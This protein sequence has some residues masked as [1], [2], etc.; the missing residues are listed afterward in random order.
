MRTT[1]LTAGTS[2]YLQNAQRYFTCGPIVKRWWYDTRSDRRYA[3]SGATMFLQVC[4]ANLGSTDTVKSVTA[5]ISRLDTMV[6]MGTAASLTF[7]N[8]P[9]GREVISEASQGM[10]VMYAPKDTA[11]R[12][13][14]TISSE[15]YPL[16]TDTLRISTGVFTD[17]KTL[18]T[19]FSL[20]QNY[21]NPF[22]PSTAIRYQLAAVS[23]VTL[24]V[25]DLLGREV[26]TL[27]NQR[28]NPGSHTVMF[29]A[30]KLPSGVYFYT[31]NAGVFRETKRMMLMK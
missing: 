7:G 10:K 8:I 30:G 26:A 19:K 9:P 21:P 31:I 14:L 20:S 25:Y 24:K 15:G 5:S 28:Q 6:L 13:L 4:L 22:N 2:R 29:D 11:V 18:P 16:W 1:D 3:D 27:V 23:H 17:G 12:L